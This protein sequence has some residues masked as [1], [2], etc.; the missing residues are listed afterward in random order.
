LTI[1]D[2]DFVYNDA[3]ITVGG[4]AANDPVLGALA[5]VPPYLSFVTASGDWFGQNGYPA[6]SIDILSVIGALIPEQYSALFGAGASLASV[7][8]PAFGGDNTIPFSLYS[9][10]ELGIP[11]IPVTPVLLSETPAA[12]WF[13]DPEAVG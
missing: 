4:T 1:N 5:C 9:C 8:A 13:P 2:S 12:P 3:A 10:P 11:P 6:P 7:T